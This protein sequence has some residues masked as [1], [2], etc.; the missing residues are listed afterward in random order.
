MMSNDFI[1]EIELVFMIFIKGVLERVYLLRN[2]TQSSQRHL[3]SEIKTDK[4][5]VFY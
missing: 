3:V 1:L 4:A 2:S 5:G